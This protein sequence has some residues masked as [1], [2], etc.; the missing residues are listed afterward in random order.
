MSQPDDDKTQ[1]VTVLANGTVI[2]HYRIKQ[3][4]VW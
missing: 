4:N 3:R 2:I 1:A